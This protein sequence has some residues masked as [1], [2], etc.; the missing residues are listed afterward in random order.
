MDNK[1]FEKYA[2]GGMGIGLILLFIVL[3]FMF[4]IPA[5]IL[6]VVCKVMKGLK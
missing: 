5:V 6:A 3:A 2:K 1:D 4:P